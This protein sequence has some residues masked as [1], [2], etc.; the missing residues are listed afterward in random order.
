MK[1]LKM[2]WKSEIL[3]RSEIGFY[4]V[5][6][7]LS[8]MTA[9][10]EQGNTADKLLHWIGNLALAYFIYSVVCGQFHNDEFG[11]AAFVFTLLFSAKVTGIIRLRLDIYAEKQRL[12][13]D[14]IRH[15]RVMAKDDKIK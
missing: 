8:I 14:D 13:L 7:A 5:V 4:L 15:I 9:I 10:K 6:S 11:N 12:E 1:G 3:S 2:P